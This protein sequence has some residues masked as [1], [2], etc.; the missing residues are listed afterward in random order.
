MTARTRI[1]MTG[2]VVPLALALA[3]AVVMLV[4]G[5]SLPDPIATHWGPGG[6]ADDFGPLWGILI[7]PP[8]VALGYSIVVIA[9]IRS[10]VQST[11]AGRLTVVHKLLVATAPFVSAMVSVIAVGSVLLQRGLGDASDAPSV[12]PVVL[13]ALASGLALAVVTWF[14]LPP[15]SPPER[16]EVRDL[17]ELDLPVTARAT[18]VQSAAPG[19]VLGELAVVL[20]V[21]SAVGAVVAFSAGAPLPVVLVLLLVTLV[22][23]VASG[24]LF[25]RVSVD[26]RGFRAVSGLGWPRFV[27]PL[28]D[29]E[30]AAVVEVNPIG[31]FGGWGLRWLPGSRLGI[32]L[33]SGPAIEVTRHNGRSLVVTV[34]GAPMGAALVNAL[35]STREGA[36]GR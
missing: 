25:W 23:A 17:P 8:I 7:L 15:A 10:A 16:T 18:W 34:P 29:I 21:V 6:V 3:A 5:P 27:Y 22:L 31:D 13:V 11:P 12:V 28:S 14:V 35:V 4:A 30:A 9:V 26:R 36:S 20:P 24:C 2:I 32:V 33:R 1:I 19:R